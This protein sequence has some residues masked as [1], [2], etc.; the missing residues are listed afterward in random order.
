M[1]MNVHQATC[2]LLRV[3]EHN[4]SLV[5][6]DCISASSKSDTFVLKS[7]AILLGVYLLCWTPY[8]VVCLMALIGYADYIT[9]L[10]VELPCLC[11]KTAAVWDPC[12]YAFRYPKFRVLLQRQFG[13]LRLTKNKVS[14]VK[15]SFS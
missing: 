12:I 6:F 2:T 8:S 9:P 15:I 14:Y 4:L 11:A 1:Y 5:S 10:M 7:S 13:F 3:H